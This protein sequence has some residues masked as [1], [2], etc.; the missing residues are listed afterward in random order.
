MGSPAI[1]AI[2]RHPI[3]ATLV[4]F[5][6]VCFTLTLLTDITYWRSGNLMWANFSAWLVVVGIVVRAIAALAGVVDLLGARG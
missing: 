3:H 1:V 4:Q 5:P 6:I 2:A